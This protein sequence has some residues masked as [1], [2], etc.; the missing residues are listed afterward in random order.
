MS[1]EK[2][3]PPVSDGKPRRT[4]KMRALFLVLPPEAEIGELVRILPCESKPDVREKIKDAKIDV[5]N[6]ADHVKLLRGDYVRM[7]LGT[8]VVLKF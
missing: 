3:P 1:E 8:Q 4:R 7:N 5:T 2:Q 6:F